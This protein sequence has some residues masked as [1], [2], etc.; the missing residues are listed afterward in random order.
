MISGVAGTFVYR[1]KFKKNT[2]F[3]R[4][5]F[6]PVR[7]PNGPFIVLGKQNPEF[8]FKNPKNPEKI[9]P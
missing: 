7:C 2:D 9:N 6:G 4:F 3:H 8:F 5:D 1:P